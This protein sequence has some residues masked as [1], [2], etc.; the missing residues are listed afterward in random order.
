MS[1][2]KKPSKRFE[3]SALV[4]RLVPWLLGLLLLGLVAAFMITLL[5]LAG[6]LPG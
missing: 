2:D 5:A 1:P 6:I 4:E 3:P